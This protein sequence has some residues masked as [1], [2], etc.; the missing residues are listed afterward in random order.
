MTQHIDLSTL[1]LDQLTPGL[2]VELVFAYDYT[3]GTIVPAD[4]PGTD[5]IGVKD[6]RID[7]VWKLHRDNGR[8]NCYNSDHLFVLGFGGIRGLWTAEKP[9]DADDWNREICGITH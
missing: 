7:Y 9:W 1:K 6:D 2:R 4:G 5:T 8:D 3:H